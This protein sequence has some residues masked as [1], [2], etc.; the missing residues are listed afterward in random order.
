VMT[1][2]RWLPIFFNVTPPD[3]LGPD[4][5]GDLVDR[6]P[7]SVD[8]LRNLVMSMVRER[9]TGF[10]VPGNRRRSFKRRRRAAI[11]VAHGLR[12]TLDWL[13]GVQSEPLSDIVSA[14]STALV[15]HFG[16]PTMAKCVVAVKLVEDM[17]G[18]LVHHR[19]RDFLPQFSLKPRGDGTERFG[20]YHNTL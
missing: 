3:G 8:V 9:G 6:G 12:K 14:F 2:S 18:R 16:V 13:W 11:R 4:V 17:Q 7:N 19:V 5:V 10:A 1:R 15:S 20:Y